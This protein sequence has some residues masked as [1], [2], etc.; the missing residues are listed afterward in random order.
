MSERSVK[1]HIMSLLNGLTVP[2]IDGALAVDVELPSI[3]VPE[4]PLGWVW[5]SG[6]DEKRSGGSHGTGYKQLVYDVA[7][8]LVWDVDPSTATDQSQFDDLVEAAV[9]T[10]RGATLQVTLTDSITN[11][12]S[13]LMNLGESIKVT[14]EEPAAL[15][16]QGPIRYVATITTTAQ[17]LVIG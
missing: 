4:T 6:W 1:A 17:E 14:R 8:V 10:L 16:E 7:A 12:T 15:T 11:R 9:F 5:A 13:T 2:T 3:T